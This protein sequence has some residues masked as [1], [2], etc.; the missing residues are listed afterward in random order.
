MFNE[1]PRKAYYSDIVGIIG[2]TVVS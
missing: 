1:L 2:E